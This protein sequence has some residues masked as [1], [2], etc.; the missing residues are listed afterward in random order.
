MQ[1]F[2]GIRHWPINLCTSTIIKQKLTFDVYYDL[3]LKRFNIQLN[4]PTNQYS[5]FEFKK[6]LS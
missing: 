2:K 5:I 4:K 6:L 1:G 3:W